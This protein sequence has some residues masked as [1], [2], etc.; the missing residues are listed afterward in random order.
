MERAKFVVSLLQLAATISIA[1]FVHQWT[2]SSATQTAL[3]EI[4]EQTRTIGLALQPDLDRAK[5]SWT[6]GEIDTIVKNSKNDV[7]GNI[8]SLLNEYESLAAGVNAGVY[9]K[10][11][12]A[13][14]RKN[15]LVSTCKKFR[16]FIDSRQKDVDPEAWQQLVRLA[17]TWGK[18]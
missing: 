6:A 9:N 10:E 1:W 2:V 7:Q 8:I 3:V 15:A 5:A 16:G 17:N 13:A 14:S 4:K 18:C 11:L 12:V